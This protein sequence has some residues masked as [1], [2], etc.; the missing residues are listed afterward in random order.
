[1]KKVSYTDRPLMLTKEEK[2]F[3][4]KHHDLMYRYMRVHKLDLAEWYDI[5]II[6]YL[7]A[8]KKYHEYER[9]QSL[10]F[11]QVFFRTLDNARSNYWRDMNRKKRCPEGGIWSYEGLRSAIYNEENGEE[12]ILDRLQDISTCLAMENIISDSMDVKN[13]INELK[14]YRQ[15]EIVYLLLDG[16]CGIEIQKILRMSLQ[17]YTKAIG[18]IRKTLEGLI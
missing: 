8:V 15:K 11:E 9:L 7:Q 18:E 16:Y 2:I 6:P 3:A 12:D 4:E 10:K 1:M 17:S 13:M 5:L 14:Q